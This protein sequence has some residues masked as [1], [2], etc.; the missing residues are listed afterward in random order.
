MIATDVTVGKDARLAIGDETIFN[1]G[2]SI[3]TQSAVSIGRRCMFGSFVRISDESFGR[4]A[5][6]ILGDDVW[7]AHGAI[8]EPGVTIGDGSV[9]SAGSVVTADVPARSIAL[10]NPARVMSLDLTVR[11]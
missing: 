11:S 1:Y 6:V 9:V 7:V 4:V 8:I 3:A 10:G 2:V 5:P